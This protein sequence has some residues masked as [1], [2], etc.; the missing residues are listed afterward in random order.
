MPIVRHEGAAGP[1]YADQWTHDDYMGARAVHW[2]QRSPLPPDGAFIFSVDEGEMFGTIP[3]EVAQWLD[4]NGVVYGTAVL[5][6]WAFVFITDP[7][8]ATHF[9]LRFL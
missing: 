6:F 7:V 9:K 8:A 3:P 2:H 5:V 4:D 1:Y